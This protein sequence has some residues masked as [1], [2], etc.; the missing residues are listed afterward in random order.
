MNTQMEEP[1]NLLLGRKTYEIF[2]V[3]W[4]NA[5][6]KP[7]ADKLNAAKKYVIS[8]TIHKLD[9]KNSTLIIGN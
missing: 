9:W 6:N 5:K 4:P 8:R 7:L 1:F 3:Y 2:A